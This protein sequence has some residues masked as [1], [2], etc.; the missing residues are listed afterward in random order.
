MKFNFSKCFYLLERQ[1][2]FLLK[3]K[4][5]LTYLEEFSKNMTLKE[6]RGGWI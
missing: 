5:L 2:I 4:P 1:V 6:V 3:D